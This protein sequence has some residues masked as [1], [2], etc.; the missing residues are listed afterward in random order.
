M[1][2]EA[3]TIPNTMM[4]ERTESCKNEILMRKL[5]LFFHR[6]PPTEL[7]DRDRTEPSAI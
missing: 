4:N 5:L 6:L 7:S 1:L 2:L 3:V